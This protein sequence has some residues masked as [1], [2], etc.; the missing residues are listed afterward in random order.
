MTVWMCARCGSTEWYE[1]Y[2][3]SATNRHYSSLERGEN[4]D[5]EYQDDSE[6]S[7]DSD[8]ERCQSCDSNDLLD[9]DGFGDEQIEFLRNCASR[10]S[11]AE[12]YD[13]ISRGE[14]IEPKAPRKGKLIG[15]KAIQ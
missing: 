4:Y 11:R 10:E 3:T 5:N 13:K 2:Y 12:A 6:E 7:G 8:G 14:T 1:D 15:G 9:I